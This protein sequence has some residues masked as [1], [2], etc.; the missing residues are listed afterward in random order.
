[1]ST[2]TIMFNDLKLYKVYYKHV[3][4]FKMGTQLLSCS[5][6]RVVNKCLLVAILKHYLVKR[7]LEYILYLK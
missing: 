7:I 4:N 1:M 2:E 6:C 5:A 3:V